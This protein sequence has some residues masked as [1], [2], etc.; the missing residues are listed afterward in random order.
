MPRKTFNLALTVTVD[1]S[2]GGS[3]RE[4]V[5]LDGHD[6]EILIVPR[7]GLRDGIEKTGISLGPRGG[8]R[9]CATCSCA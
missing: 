8:G 7:K 3:H 1:P 4:L 2:A 9:H 6:Y 5:K